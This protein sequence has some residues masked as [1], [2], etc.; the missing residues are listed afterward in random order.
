MPFSSGPYTI[1][2][3]QFIFDRNGVQIGHVQGPGSA[4]AN[5]NL[6]ATVWEALI[7]LHEYVSTDQCTD[8]PEGEQCKFCSSMNIIRRAMGQPDQQVPLLTWFGRFKEQ[9]Q[10]AQNYRDLFEKDRAKRNQVVSDIQ[11]RI[12]S[13][14]AKLER[15]RV[16]YPAEANAVAHAIAELTM[17]KAALES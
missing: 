16:P 13:L 9:Q 8:H 7:M 17:F 12:F 14:S 5:A 6:F 10:I 4:Q 11:H 2:D 1:Q 15:L 3:E